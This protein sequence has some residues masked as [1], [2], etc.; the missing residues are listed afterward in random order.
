MSRQKEYV[1]V[2]RERITEL[3][4]KIDNLQILGVIYRFIANMTKEDGKE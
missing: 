2:E 1:L 3:I 4:A